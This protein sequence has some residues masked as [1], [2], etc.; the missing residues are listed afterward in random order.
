MATQTLLIEGTFSELALELADYIDSLK[1]GTDLSEALNKPI[2]DIESAQSAEDSSK[3][4]SLHKAQRKVL[5]E[6]CRHAG[7]LL[8]TPERGN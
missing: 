7:V 4:D 8:D 6:I 3:S 1:P 5:Q 2:K